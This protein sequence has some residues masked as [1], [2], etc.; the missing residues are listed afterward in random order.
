MIAGILANIIL[1]ISTDMALHAAGVFPPL[2][3]PAIF[4]TPLLLLATAYR[5]VYG[6]EGGY[7]TARL[8]PNHPM[9]HAPVLG[10]IGLAACGAGALAMWG[11]GPAWYPVALVILAV[12]C[13]WASGRLGVMELEKS[14]AN[15]SGNLATRIPQSESPRV[16]A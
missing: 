5:T 7:L 16:T 8:A 10:I 3:E 2:S 11:V 6:F 14:A 4:T 1:S 9:G 15:A 13:A 12:P